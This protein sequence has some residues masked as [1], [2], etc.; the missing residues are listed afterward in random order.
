MVLTFIVNLMCS[1]NFARSNERGG[2]TFKFFASR[3]R[4]KIFEQKS[5]EIIR[6]WRKLHTED[7]H[8]T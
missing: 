5:R 2:H 7:V 8:K 1:N 3:E 4:G 6:G